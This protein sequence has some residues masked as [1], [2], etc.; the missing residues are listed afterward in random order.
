MTRSRWV[1]L[2]RCGLA[3]AAIAA[4]EP[5]SAQTV[6]VRSAPAG[7]AIEVQLN[8]DA[9]RTGAAD[10]NG[11]AMLA[12]GFPSSNAEEVDVRFAVDVCAAAVRVYM[13]SAG[14]GP[15]APAAGCNRTAIPDLFAMRRV[16]TFVVEVDGTGAN[17]HLTQGP[18]PPEWLGAAQAARAARMRFQTPPPAALVASGGLGISTFGKAV[19]AACGNV[20]SCRGDDLSGAASAGATFWLKNWVG[21]QVTFARPAKVTANGSGDTFRFN[22]TLDTRLVTVAAA[23][24]ARARAARIY[25]LVGTAHHQATLVTSETIPDATI[26]VGDS[27]VTV[28]GGTQSFAHRTEGW[29]WLFGGGVEAWA[30]RRL[31]IFV[32][33]QRARLKA[34]DIGSAEGGIDD[35]VMLIVA[36]LRLRLLR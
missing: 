6:I 3:L 16:T 32:E 23:F 12:V 7:A 26:T 10:S 4:A 24:G 14:A 5:A 8:A 33:M 25:G 15:P 19:D 11:D 9:A 34:T 18:P 28:P 2:W 22:T 29:N 13:R 17:L 31:A 30:T 1:W 27:T 21:A 35:N 36:G 20:T